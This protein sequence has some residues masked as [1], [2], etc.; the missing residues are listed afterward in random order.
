MTTAYRPV[1]L[2]AEPLAHALVRPG[3]LWRDV[4]VVPET[5]STNT[6]LLAGGGAPPGS[7]LVAERQTAGRGRQGRSWISPAGSALHVSALIRPEAVPASRWSWLPLLAGTS[8]A[9]VVTRFCVLGAALKWPND[10]LAVSADPQ[11]QPAGK[12]AGILTERSGEAVV[13]GIGVN[14]S[15]GSDELPSGATSLAAQGARWISRQQLLV[16]LLREFETAFGRWTEAGGDPDRSGARQLYR[17]MCGTLGSRVRVELPGGRELHG[18]ARDVDPAGQLLLDTDE[19][20]TAV[21][22]GDVIHLR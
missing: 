21:A 13:V 14:I 3:G 19:G 4:R 20:E 9:T 7:V 16:A 2:T 15:A 11:E 6:D 17:H 5:A 12:L 10:L 22:A 8:L 1:P 18:T